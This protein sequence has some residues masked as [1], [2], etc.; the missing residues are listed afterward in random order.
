MYRCPICSFAASSRT[1]FSN[2][3]S[4]VEKLTGENLE[5]IRLREFHPDID[6][7]QLIALYVSGEEGWS[8]I[9]S[10]YGVDINNLLLLRGIKR[11]QAEEKATAGYKKRY[12]AGCMRTLGVSNPSQLQAVKDKKRATCKERFG[13]SCNLQEQKVRERANATWLANKV[14]NIA[15]IRQATITKHGVENVAQIPSAR[16][17]NSKSQKAR[18]SAMS[19]DERRNATAAARAKLTSMPNWSSKVEERVCRLCTAIFPETRRHVFLF[20][21]NYDI[22]VGKTLI[23]VNGDFWHANPALGYVRSD[24]LLSGWKV[25]EVWDKDVAKRRKAEAAGYKVVTLWERDINS[26]SD[27]DII[28][29]LTNEVLT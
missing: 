21:F 26:M 27:C 11:T 25:G 5:M 12:A 16:V 28:A 14:K 2:H 22:Q 6:I 20:K 29:I 24:E 9:R 7:E 15:A 10:K 3:L 1:G 17:A 13:A 4:R 8:S 19:A 18:F 23:E